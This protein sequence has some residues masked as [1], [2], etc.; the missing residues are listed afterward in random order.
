MKYIYFS[1]YLI[2]ILLLILIFFNFINIEDYKYLIQE[3]FID[4]NFFEKK[5]FLIF[6]IFFF[7]YIFIIILN[8]PLTTFITIYSAGLVGV[9]E[10]II[11]VFFASSVGTYL[12]LIVNRHFNKKDQFIKD[13]LIKL[14]L[15]FEPKIILVILL[16][17]I[18]IIPFSWVIIYLS[19]TNFSP[20]KFLFSYSIG[21]LV[22][23][24]LFA[25]LGNALFKNDI[26]LTTIILL[27]F[28]FIIILGNLIKKY[29]FKS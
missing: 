16:K 11:F 12:C 2:N 21:S 7:F 5:K 22:S 13:K 26:Y 4:N 1:T 14:N 23:I 9:Y 3:Y 15:L 19:N 29:L 6:F 24:S 27:L 25:N 17:A 8:L 20:I 28:L 18:P 10:T